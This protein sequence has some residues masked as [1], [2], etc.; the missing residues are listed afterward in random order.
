MMVRKWKKRYQL[1]SSSS[2]P[3][4]WLLFH[5]EGILL[6]LTHH[7]TKQPENV[8]KRSRR[9]HAQTTRS[10]AAAAIPKTKQPLLKPT[11]IFVFS[12]RRLIVVLFWEY[13]SPRINAT[14]VTPKNGSTA[15]TKWCAD[16]EKNRKAQPK[17]PKAKQ[18]D[19]ICRR[20]FC[21]SN[22]EMNEKIVIVWESQ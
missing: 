7:N 10:D 6:S 4:S 2:W 19:S 22:S 1:I 9:C 14:T 8:K 17:R 5:F 12:T 21:L 15:A 20:F 18:E 3:R 16:A 13:M 11:D